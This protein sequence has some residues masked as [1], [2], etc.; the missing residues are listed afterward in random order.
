MHGSSLTECTT[1]A[2]PAPTL[3]TCVG[4]APHDPP[5]ARL[6]ALG[7][8]GMMAGTLQLSRALADRKLADQLLE[9]G[10]RNVLALLD[11]EQHN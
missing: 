7:L 9:Q 10:M 6:R 5:S 1:D 8:L 2:T 11:A 4:L 3:D